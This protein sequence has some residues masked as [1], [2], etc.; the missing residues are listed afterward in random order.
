MEFAAAR[1]MSEIA[2]SLR[3]GLLGPLFDA[4]ELA[5]VLELA[6]AL[7]RDASE[8]HHELAALMAESMDILARVALG[9]HVDQQEVAR[10]R[11]SARRSGRADIALLPLRAI[12]LASASTGDRDGVAAALREIEALPGIET[13]SDLASALPSLTRAALA[14]DDDAGPERLQRL[15]VA[16]FP[17]ASHAIVASNAALAEARGDR[18]AAIAGYT[19][20]ATRW[21]DFGVV[22]EEA[23]A[24]AGLG[25]CLL[26]G[27]RPDEA[28]P[29][30]RASLERWG[31]MGATPM[32]TAVDAL[33]ADAAASAAAVLPTPGSASGTGRTSA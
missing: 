16:P 14:I 23:F 21:R 28:V 13:V 18:D 20:A 22:P 11:E 7:R 31:A 26:A 4:G 33:L 29:T 15:L 30:L 2:L 17:Y 19:D 9:D 27:G 25:R 6:D 24:L 32:V 3:A 10:V 1:G 8:R 5:E 12:V